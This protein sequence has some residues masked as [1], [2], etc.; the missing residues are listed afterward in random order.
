V[1]SQSVENLLNVL[2]VFCLILVEDEDVIQIFHHKRIGER[3]Q[4]IIHHPHENIWGIFQD[5]GHDQPF[6][7]NLFGLE[8]SLPW[9]SLLRPGGIHSSYK[10]Y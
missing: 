8:G 5:K 7:N 10:S 1:F 9:Y 3:M 4:D 6:K 2:Q